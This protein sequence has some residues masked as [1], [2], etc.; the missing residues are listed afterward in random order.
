M[1][2]ALVP[3]SDLLPGFYAA[4]NHAPAWT[5][6][7]APVPA[8]SALADALEG[9]RAHGLEP[10]DYRKTQIS[11]LLALV[12]ET[13]ARGETPDPELLADLDLLLTDAFLVYGVHLLS[14]RVNPLTIEPS[15]S[16]GKPETD[17]AALLEEVRK[18]GAV[19][20]ALEGLAPRFPEY[21]ALRKEMDRHRELALAEDLPK[22]PAVT[23]L[24]PGKRNP[25]VPFIRDRL[26]AL[27]YLDKA[28]PAPAK[29]E[30]DVYSAGM[31][32]AVKRFQA[33]NGLEPDSLVGGATVE[34]FNRGPDEKL[35]K[36]LANLERW[37]WMPRVLGD[38]HILVNVA[39][40]TLRVRENGAEVLS[41][42]VI[43]GQAARRTPVFSAEMQSIIFNPYW[44][45]PRKIAVED[46]LPL[47]RKDP[48]YLAK[49]KFKVFIGRGETAQE[50]NPD[51]IN[52][53]AL[54]KDHFPYRL[55]QDPG[56]VNALG[57]IKFLFPNP[58]AVYIHDTPTRR[59]F[60][61]AQRN[62]S[63][64]CIR[65]EKPVELAAYLLADKE[66]WNQEKVQKVLDSKVNRHIALT[67]PMPVHIVYFTAWTDGEGRTVFRND[68]YGRDGA[69]LDA[70]RGKRKGGA[71]AGKADRAEDG[72]V[73]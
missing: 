22:I 68:P 17:L 39:D 19:A 32:E 11:E 56:P 46:K 24:K 48:L 21:N 64:G 52:W 1:E 61:K 8:A 35:G 69:L 38:R 20:E 53:S 45:V 63:S 42:R 66:G 73:E 2:E 10:E 14:G 6:A 50:I 28:S 71:K 29:G 57:R 23:L 16:P 13:R 55:R 12:S 34:A 47:I 58:Y 30:E 49:N 3:A 62:F 43:V 25:A 65:I 36:I 4:R 31:A 37:R 26:I 51:G 72:D 59:L 40:Y 33:D 60:D 67:R 41:M 70:L 15:V 44:N 18:T 7:G 27:A 5:A 9:A 54:N